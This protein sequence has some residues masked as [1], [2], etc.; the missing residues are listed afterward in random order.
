MSGMLA[1]QL[2][3]GPSGGLGQQPV[4][5]S[6]GA[7]AAVPATAPHPLAT[8][9][10]ALAD[11]HSQAQANFAATSKVMSSLAQVREQMIS[12]VKLG[13]TIQPED[14]M[15]AAGK[16][17]GHGQDPMAIVGLLADMPE[18]GGEPMAAWIAQHA[19][20]IIAKSQEAAQVHAATQHQLGV[21]GM[22]S[23]VAHSLGGQ[24]SGQ[25][26][27]AQAQPPAPAANPL[28]GG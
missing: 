10:S 8:H 27:P 20:M 21:A 3:S 23:L 6:A 26:Q 16:L 25:I 9:L 7:A 14:V 24:P 19:E 5:P 15:T 12:L 2:Q 1:G 11:A 18:T 4:D 28:T 22:T 17:V 13:D